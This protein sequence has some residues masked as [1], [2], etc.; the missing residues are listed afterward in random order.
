MTKQLIRAAATTVLGLSLTAGFAAADI[1]NTGP[2]SN[3]KESSKV[4]NSLTVD[5]NNNLSASNDNSQKAKTGDA[6]VKHNTTGGDATSGDA[7]NDNSFD[8]S[9]SVDNSAGL[10]SWSFS[11]GPS[12][13]GD[14]DTTGPDSNN[15]ISSRVTNRV[16]ITNNNNVSVSNDNYQRASTGDAS[17]SGNTTGGSAT[18]GSASNT[19]S[20]SVT[21]SVTN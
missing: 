17:V 11:N 19:N 1:S 20:S 16:N 15:T 5:N 4:K 8:G 2:D 21:L 13:L 10:G 14:I 7:S 12:S 18:S 6:K 9:V 3:N